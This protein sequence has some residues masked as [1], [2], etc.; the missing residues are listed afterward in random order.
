MRGYM[1]LV[2]TPRIVIYIIYK[3]TKMTTNQ[4]LQ[5]DCRAAENKVT[6]QKVLR[7]IKPLSKCPVEYDVP[8]EKLERCLKV[9]CNNYNF[10]IPSISP[11]VCSADKEIIWKCRITNG[12]TLE[13]VGV[14]YGCT[15]YEC[16]AK[17]VIL[18]YSRTRKK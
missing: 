15:F 4:I 12:R 3:G 2:A 10:F 7:I 13:D 14:T 9:L 11:D 5:L 8:V 18:L 6:V 16:L 17:A 1:W